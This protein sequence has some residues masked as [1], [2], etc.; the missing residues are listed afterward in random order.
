MADVLL[1]YILFVL[2]VLFFFLRWFS[3]RYS[4][5]IVFSGVCRN[6]FSPLSEQLME[7]TDCAKFFVTH[8][9]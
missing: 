3:R 5:R 8:F 4:E 7:V 2:L 6:I 1:V 9:N